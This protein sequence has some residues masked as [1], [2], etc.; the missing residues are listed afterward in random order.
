MQSSICSGYICVQLAPDYYQDHELK[1]REDSKV[2]SFK[3]SVLSCLE[4][5]VLK[6]H[7]QTLKANSYMK[8]FKLIYTINVCFALYKSFSTIDYV[9]AQCLM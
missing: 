3:L 8:L 9:A 1:G 5:I 6:D 2:V 4:W 7:I